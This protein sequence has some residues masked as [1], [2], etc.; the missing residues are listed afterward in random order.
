VRRVVP[1]YI[2]E[3]REERLVIAKMIV[4]LRGVVAN[5]VEESDTTGDETREHVDNQIH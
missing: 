4:N 2:Q 1:G 3:N 5:R